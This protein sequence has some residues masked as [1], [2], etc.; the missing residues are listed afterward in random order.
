MKFY[1]CRTSNSLLYPLIFI[2]NVFFVSQ[3]EDCAFLKVYLRHGTFCKCFIFFYFT[4]N[5]AHSTAEWPYWQHATYSV[6]HVF[7]M[8]GIRRSHH[9]EDRSGSC[10]RYLWRT[11]D[12]RAVQ[13]DC[14]EV[15]W[16]PHWSG[17][18]DL[19]LSGS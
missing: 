7:G 14:W 9:K 8:T 11:C 10:I 2:I 17:P 4:K 5:H 13:H 3:K 6:A 12:S 16:L 15:G 18:V 1:H 19:G